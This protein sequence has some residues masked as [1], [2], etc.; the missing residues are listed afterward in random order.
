MERLNYNPESENQKFPV[1]NP[2]NIN[3]DQI[4]ELSKTDQGIYYLPIPRLHE[5]EE[6]TKLYQEKMAKESD[7]RALQ[8]KETAKRLEKINQ[9]IAKIKAENENYLLNNLKDLILKTSQGEFGLGYKVKVSYP[10][11]RGFGPNQPIKY[12]YPLGLKAAKELSKLLQQEHSIRGSQ[13]ISWHNLDQKFGGYMT[14]DCDNLDA[15]GYYVL[16]NYRPENEK[17]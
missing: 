8:A 9:L 5:K 17:I 3:L 14:R 10:K 16:I 7:P 15:L 13:I 12:I 11:L 6:F 2:E 4:S 1:V